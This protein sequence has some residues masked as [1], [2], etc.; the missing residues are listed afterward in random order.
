[1]Q[2]TDSPPPTGGGPALQS[3]LATR[4]SSGCLSAAFFLA[5]PRQSS[6][7]AHLRCKHL[8]QYG[9]N[10]LH[11]TVQAPCTGRCKHLAQYG[12]NTLHR[13]VQTPCTVRC[14]HFA[15]GGANTLHRAVQAPCTRRCKHL[16]QPLSLR[17]PLGGEAIQHEGTSSGC[18]ATGLLR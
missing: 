9:A 1:M 11:S 10:T 18:L 15:Q 16:A 4:T 14:K 3:L 7:K 13:A 8:A 6:C 17:A 12:A 2:E 5:Q